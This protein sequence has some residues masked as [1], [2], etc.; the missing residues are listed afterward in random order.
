MAG[1]LLV[2]TF[3]GGIYSNGFDAAPEIWQYLLIGLLWG[4]NIATLVIV[5]AAARHA[6]CNRQMLPPANGKNAYSWAS[7]L[8]I[9]FSSVVVAGVAVGFLLA[10]FSPA[11]TT[12]VIGHF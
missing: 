8:G 12:T 2:T 9:T 7:V 11:Q 3:V 10:A 5:L 6:F 1:V 4:I